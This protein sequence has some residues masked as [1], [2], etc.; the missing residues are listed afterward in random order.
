M[1]IKLDFISN[2]SSTSFVYISDKE[3]TK[4]AFLKAAG[5]DEGSPVA[6]LFSDMYFE[7]SGELK[8]GVKLKTTGELEELRDN[9][10]FTPEVLDKMRD[11]IEAGQ[12]VKTGSLDSD[13]SLAESALCM[14][15]FE[16]ESD[17]FYINAYN[18]YW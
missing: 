12:T 5:V 10:S 18:N 14:E 17:D 11:A 15:I 4:E 16:V 8:Y 1:K 6:D 7:I 3:L 13:G 9:G 2:S